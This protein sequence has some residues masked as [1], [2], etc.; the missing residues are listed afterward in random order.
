[1]NILRRLCLALFPVWF[2]LCAASGAVA[3]DTPYTF[4]NPEHEARYKRLIAE[5]RCLVCQ[6]Q[7]IEDSHASL[8]QDL[9]AEVYQQVTRG[10]SEE[11]VVAYLVDRYGDFVRYRP[12][13]K[14][15]TALLWLGPALLVGVGGWIAWRTI[16]RHTP[17]AGPSVTEEEEE[18]LT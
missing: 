2:A 14:P 1:M 16:R 12:P 7:N 10:A 4:D 6:N 5:L 15:S 9:R 13:F 17:A 3:A 11:A 8:A 18:S